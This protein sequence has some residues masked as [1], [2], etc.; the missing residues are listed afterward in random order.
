MPLLLLSGFGN[1]LGLGGLVLEKAE[2]G[3]AL[4]E[5]ASV[6]EAADALREFE[7]AAMLG[8]DEAALGEKWGGTQESEDAGV[9]IFL[10]VG[11]I[12]ENEIERRVDGFVAGAELF[13]SAEGVERKDLHAASD[14]QRFEIAADENA[15]RGVIF[16]EDGF[17]GAAAQRFDANRTGAGE[18]VEEARAAHVGA[19]HVE[20]SFAQTVA[21]GAERSTLQGL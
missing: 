5:E 2:G 16:D 19:K 15:G 21:G 11:R 18:N 3:V 8:D 6:Q 4:A 7:G 13:E 12:D 20:E 10:G 1:L 9:L 14:C 17:D